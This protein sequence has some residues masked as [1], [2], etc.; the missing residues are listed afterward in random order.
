MSLSLIDQASQQPANCGV[1][2]EAQ[3]NDFREEV[4]NDELNCDDAEPIKFLA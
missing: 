3:D 2:I 1:A 4:V